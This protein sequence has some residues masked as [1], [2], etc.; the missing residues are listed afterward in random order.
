MA[1]NFPP[2]K[3]DIKFRGTG[4][5]SAGVKGLIMVWAE[6]SADNAEAILLYEQVIEQYLKQ[7]VSK[8]RYKAQ[9]LERQIE[10]IESEIRP[11]MPGEEKAKVVLSNLVRKWGRIMTKIDAIDDVSA[12]EITSGATIV[13]YGSQLMAT[14]KHDTIIRM[15]TAVTPDDTEQNSPFLP[16]T[17]AG[18]KLRCID[19]TISL[20]PICDIIA[21]VWASLIQLRASEQNAGISDGDWAYLCPTAKSFTATEFEALLALIQVEV[22]GFR[23]FSKL[24]TPCMPV[25]WK[26]DVDTINVY[27]C[28][29]ARGS[30]ILQCIPMRDDTNTTHHE[31]NE[32]QPAYIHWNQAIGLSHDLDIM[33][34]FRIPAATATPGFVAIQ[35]ASATRLALLVAYQDDTGLFQYADTGVAHDYI[36]NVAANQ[37]RNWVGFLN[38]KHPMCVYKANDYLSADQWNANLVQYL[39]NPARF[40][41]FELKSPALGRVM[42]DI[43]KIKLA[44][45]SRPI[46]SIDPM[47]PPR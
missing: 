35:E 33:P 26:N 32:N 8:W 3:F 1:N 38:S 15:L 40:A 36:Q 24:G 46:E 29:S 34:L 12:A 11:L 2:S 5:T 10:K 22:E 45:S 42:K 20:P 41:G 23:L 27:S 28:F 37:A 21:D 7:V 43:L 47:A 18:L 25:D 44:E 31:F 39:S 30:V 17:R 16:D 4:V 6:L 13:H 19:G 9:L 14:L